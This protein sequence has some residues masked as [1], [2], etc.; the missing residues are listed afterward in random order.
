MFMLRV[1]AAGA[2]VAWS[3]LAASIIPGDAR[4][5]EQLFQTEQCVQCH[6]IKGKGGV[7][8][9]D[10]ARRVDRD[11]TPAVMASLMWNHAPE[12]WAAMKER[13]VTKGSMTPEKAADLFAYFVSA[14]YFEKPGDA[15]RG[16]Q[17]FAAKHC[18]ECHGI[19]SSPGGRGA[20]RWPNGNRWPTRWCW[21]SRCGITAPRCARNSP[22]RSWP[23]RTI[24]AQELTD[25][26]VYLQNL[27]ET[28]SLAANFAFPPSDTGEK[29]FVSKGC[30]G[31]H[32]GKR[33][34]EALLKNQTL[35][36]I[37]VDMWNHQ[38]NMKNPPPELS[39][40]EMRQILSY[41]WARQYFR[42]NGNAE[43]GKK[44]F[45]REELRHLP[46]R[47]AA[48]RSSARA[49]TPIPTSRWSRRCGITAR[50]CWS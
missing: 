1:M 6:S 8:A 39:Q 41:I 50:R 24:T 20:R 16:K 12:M 3:A 40:E 4:R 18:A 29:L 9:P 38:P 19:T 48:L 15:A 10:L 34:L 49:R 21:R 44:V 11:Y 5:G 35:T 37:A 7:L 32:T 17:A 26:L 13:G 27:P 46:Q 28:R 25:M 36:D 23:G 22:R 45:T 42:G 2:L 31:C 30:A 14:R 43:R 33:A 47:A